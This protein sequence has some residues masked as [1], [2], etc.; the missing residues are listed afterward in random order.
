MDELMLE[1]LCLKEILKHTQKCIEVIFVW[2]DAVIYIVI[3]FSVNNSVNVAC[4]VL[5]AL[6]ED[7][8]PFQQSACF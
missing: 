1:E 2:N 5:L 4:M 7:P 3:N 6:L 8:Y